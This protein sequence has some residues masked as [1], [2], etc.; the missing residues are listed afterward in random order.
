MLNIFWLCSEGL[1]G[2][3]WRQQSVSRQCGRYLAA[4]RT[5]SK[6]NVKALPAGGQ[7]SQPLKEKDREMKGQEK[8]KNTTSSNHYLGFG[9]SMSSCKRLFQCTLI[10]AHFKGI[11]KI[12]P[13]LSGILRAFFFVEL[14][15]VPLPL[16]GLKK[17]VIPAQVD[18]WKGSLSALTLLHLK[19]PLY[20]VHVNVAHVSL[21]EHWQ[22]LAYICDS[23]VNCTE[24]IHCSCLLV[25]MQ[26]CD[27]SM[28]KWHS[29]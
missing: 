24:W 13:I 22:A 25:W 12:L 29:K 19:L 28:L 7:R 16:L 20:L 4:V 6:N 10:T 5:L 1:S 23:D 11:F 3:V 14:P 18:V 15:N 2:A 9:V 21:L 26:I 8:K 17:R 27:S